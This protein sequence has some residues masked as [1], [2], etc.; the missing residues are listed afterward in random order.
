M[1]NSVGKFEEFIV[2]MSFSFVSLYT[3]VFDVNLS[4]LKT[5]FMF[6]SWRNVFVVVVVVPNIV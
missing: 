4:K 3:S 6:L 1:D 5:V 2:L